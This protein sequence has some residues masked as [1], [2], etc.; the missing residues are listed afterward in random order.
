MGLLS[1]EMARQGRCT[2]HEIH[3]HCAR[4]SPHVPVTLELGQH[5][6]KGRPQGYQILVGSGRVRCE[7][8][9]GIL[10]KKAISLK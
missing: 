2:Q 4:L 5:V 8:G 10:L 7:M 6:A 9:K 3:E 1:E